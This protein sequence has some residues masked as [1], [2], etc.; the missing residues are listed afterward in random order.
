[1]V[2][3]RCARRVRAVNCRCDTLKFD[4]DCFLSRMYIPTN[5]LKDVNVGIGSPATPLASGWGGGM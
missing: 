3:L 2:D 4:L 1:M 5:S